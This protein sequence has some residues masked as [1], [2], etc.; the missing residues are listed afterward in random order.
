MSGTDPLLAAVLGRS[1][2]F[3]AQ[4]LADAQD[5]IISAVKGQRILV[6]GGA[7]SIGRAF[8]LEIVRHLPAALHLV[9]VSENSLVEVVRELR[10]SRVTLPADFRTYAL[11][12]TA[13]EMVALLGASDY[14][15][16]LNFS[17]LKH[18][19]SE[20]DPFTLM[21]L[22][23]VNVLGLH[24]LARRLIDG[25]TP[26]RLF[27]VSSDKAVRPASLMGA[28]KA[29]MERVLLHHSDSVAVSSARFANVAFSDGSLLE[30]FGQRLSKRQPLSAPT[31]VRR[32]FISPPEAAQLCLL[33]CF[34][35]GNGEIVFPR[36]TPESMETFADIARTFLAHHGL[37]PAECGSEDEAREMADGLGDAPTAWPC[38]FSAS[39]T[40]GEKLFEEFTHPE[41]AVDDDRYATVGVVTH[42]IR[43]EPGDLLAAIAAIESHRASGRWSADELCDLVAGVVPEFQHVAADRNLDEK[44]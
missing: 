12:F 16:V 29:L 4:D 26:V 19:R 35:C 10:A 17:A 11:D 6:I 15:Y 23:K 43:S 13:I 33:S 41:E 30:S 28:S 38:Y 20:R 39:D 8:A 3:L 44:M 1:A 40:S 9:D 18:V 42:P 2:S 36:F 14:D 21:R 31:D 37:K 32:Y 34:T 7:G 24:D 25:P 22:L 27:S 5:E